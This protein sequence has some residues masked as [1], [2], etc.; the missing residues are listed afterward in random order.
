MARRCWVDAA[1]EDLE[2]LGFPAER[3]GDLLV[4]AVAEHPAQQDDR[5]RGGEREEHPDREDD[6]HA[7]AAEEAPRVVGVDG[8]VVAARDVRD[9]PERAILDTRHRHE[10]A[11]AVKGR[12]VA[13]HHGHT[14]RREPMPRMVVITSLPATPSGCPAPVTPQGVPSAPVTPQGVPSVPVTP[15]GVPSV[16]V[17]PQGVP[18]VQSPR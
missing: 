17:T 4:E 2:L 5:H 3:D 16:P 13:A 15:Q 10:S 8:L 1:G 11:P 14:E 7:H 9:A 12:W 18:S 6:P